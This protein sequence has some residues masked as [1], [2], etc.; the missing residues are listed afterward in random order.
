M[1]IRLALHITAHLTIA[2]E[3]KITYAWLSVQL[4]KQDKTNP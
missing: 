2:A 3:N 1:Q 4:S